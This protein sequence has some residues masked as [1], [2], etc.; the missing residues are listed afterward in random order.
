QFV[1]SLDV[2]QEDFRRRRSQWRV[3]FGH[4]FCSKKGVRPNE[5]LSEWPRLFTISYFKELDSADWLCEGIN[6][7]SKPRFTE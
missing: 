3:K 4:V 2:I 5:G 7:G 6:R 1:G